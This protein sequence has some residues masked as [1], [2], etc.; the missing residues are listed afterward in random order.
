MPY[1]RRFKTGPDRRTFL[2]CIF[3]SSRL[4]LFR[5][6]LHFSREKAQKSQNRKPPRNQDG[7]FLSARLDPFSQ[8]SVLLIVTFIPHFSIGSRNL[9]NTSMECHFR[10][11]IIY[12]KIS[13]DSDILLFDLEAD[14]DA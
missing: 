3:A 10:E 7:Y 11:S 6:R 1:R 4:I 13:E 2:P 9:K 12:W 5:K 14:H 8:A